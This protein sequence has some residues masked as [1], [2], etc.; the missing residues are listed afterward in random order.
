MNRGL[1]PRSNGQIDQEQLER[2]IRH[3]GNPFAR[4]CAWV[5]LDQLLDE[6]DIEELEE[7]LR[8][9]RDRRKFRE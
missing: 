1:S 4:A 7:E 9:L 5:L 8:L 6:P 2:V 3:S